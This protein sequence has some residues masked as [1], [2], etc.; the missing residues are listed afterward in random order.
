MALQDVRELFAVDEPGGGPPPGLPLKFAPDGCS[1][2]Y[3][4]LWGDSVWQF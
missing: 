3:I 1:L 2:R 4:T